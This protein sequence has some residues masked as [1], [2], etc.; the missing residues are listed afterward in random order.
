MTILIRWTC[1]CFQSNCFVIQWCGRVF[2]FFFF[3]GPY[4]CEIESADCGSITPDADISNSLCIYPQ[5]LSMCFFHQFPLDI[6]TTTAHFL[7][8]IPFLVNE[9][10]WKGGKVEKIAFFVEQKRLCV[11]LSKTYFYHL[12]WV[13]LG[14]EESEEKKNEDWNRREKRRY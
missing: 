5:S 7:P 1:L 9:I 10:M 12:G 6:F 11:L 14:G 8:S 2:F 4:T 13:W 3:K